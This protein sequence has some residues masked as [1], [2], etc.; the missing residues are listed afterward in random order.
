MG[1][2]TVPKMS[3]HGIQKDVK[4]GEGGRPNGMC[5]EALLQG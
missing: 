4:N 5:E 2:G 3:E 1:K